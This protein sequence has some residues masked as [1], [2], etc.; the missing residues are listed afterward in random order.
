MIVIVDYEVGNVA[1]VLNM[2]KK[3]GGQAIV[4]GSQEDIS[5]ATKLVLPGVGAFDHGMQ[6][7]NDKGLPSLLKERASAGVPLM[8]ICLGMQLLGLGSEEGEMSGLGLL[9]ARFKRFDFDPAGALRVP[10]VGWNTIEI[11]KPNPL[12]VDDGQENRFYF[13]HSYHAVCDE[14][15]DVL[16]TCDYGYGFPA[17]YSRENVYGFQFHPEK[18]HRFGLDLFCRFLEL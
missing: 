18:S 4:S 14:A 11:N 17:A 5:R 16:A 6:H 12:I 9:P 3:A 1:S 13:V 7:L 15:A 2:I 10:H 8:G